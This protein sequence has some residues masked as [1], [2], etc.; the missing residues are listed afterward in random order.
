MKKRIGMLIVLFC[1]LFFSSLQAQDNS[2]DEKNKSLNF[3]RF[4][5]TIEFGLL[6]GSSHNSQKAPFS[7]MNITSYHLSPQLAVGLGIGAD[8]YNETYIPIVADIRYYFRDSKFSPFAYLQA[9]YSIAVEDEVDRD[10]YYSL[11]SIWPGPSYSDGDPRGGFLFNPGIGV[12]NM[13]NDHFGVVFSIGYRYQTLNYNI[14][15]INRLEIEYNR[16]NVKFGII[17]R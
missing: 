12:R 1:G 17:F 8:F 10:I 6:I 2:S 7:F 16:L 13:F 4:Y 15:T 11:S 5:N 3:K 14:G 9:G